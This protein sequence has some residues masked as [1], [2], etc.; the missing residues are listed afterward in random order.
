[1]ISIL[2]PDQVKQRLPQWGVLGAIEAFLERVALIVGKM[3][4]Y[5]G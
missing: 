2:G 4:P 5:G 1:M 3:L